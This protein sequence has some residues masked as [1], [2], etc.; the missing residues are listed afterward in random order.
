MLQDCIAAIATPLGEGGISIIRIS[1]DESIAIADRIFRFKGKLT[2]MTSHT[3]HYGKIVHPEDGR[4]LDE[5]LVLIMLAPKTFTAEDVV[6]VHC[7][8]GMFITQQVLQLILRAGARLA[9]PGE[10][11]KRAFLNGRIDLIQAESVI[12]LIRSKSD[13]AHR[14][15]ISQLDGKISKDISKFR[16]EMLQLLAHVEV[17]IDYPEHDTELMT[18]DEIIDS[19]NRWISVLD[20]WLRTAREGKLIREGIQTVLAGRP[21]VGKSSLLNSFVKAE[22]AIVTDIAGTTRDVIEEWIQ[23]KGY[24]L[25]LMDTAGLRDTEDL[26]EQIGVERTR[27]AIECADLILFVINANEPLSNE[28]WTL[29]KMFESR[30]VIL[31]LN[32]TDLTVNVNTDEIIFKF[33]NLRI[34]SVSVLQQTGL[35]RLETEIIDIIQVNGVIVDESSVLSRSRHI[36]LVTQARM[37]LEDA[38]SAAGMGVPIDL[39]QIDLRLAWET[40]GHLVGQTASDSLLDELFSQF[41]LGK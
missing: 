33:P 8:G 1:G 20:E 12:D 9:E 27:V 22:R 25:R 11:T 14:L 28:E 36:E 7:H 34:V 4:I 2:Q 19:T 6:E 32:K 18:Q 40:L 31:I 30:P 17:N 37:M 21:N 16:N 10:F 41:C 23:I 24:A 13:R 39:I 26:V 5:V 3:V 15:A 29:L 38:N 35:D